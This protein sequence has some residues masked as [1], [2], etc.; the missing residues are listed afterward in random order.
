MRLRSRHAWS[1]VLVALFAL[2]VLRPEGFPGLE[3]SL[4]GWLNWTS[5]LGFG[6]PHAW[7]VAPVG[8]AGT[9]R[10]K[11]LEVIA[12]EQR[13]SYYR[14][15]DELVQRQSL[16][17]TLA[18]VGRLPVALEARILRAKDA[19]SK[20]RSI[21]I[22]RGTADGVVEG[23]AV[24]QGSRLVGLVQRVDE[25]AARVQLVTDPAFRLE[26]CVRSQEGQRAGAYLRGGD[27]DA[28]ALR[29]VRVLPGFTVRRDDPVLTSNGSEKVPDGLVVGRV[30]EADDLELETLRDVR[31][32]PLFDL[33]AS[34]TVLVLLPAR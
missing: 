13:E 32:R 5:R 21:L 33:E 18:G 20:R 1:A 19:S 28:L 26:V 11:D 7:R 9:Q 16:R 24:V 27:D 12:L 31:M 30:I 34:T 6:N 14:L 15:L 3:G 8:G 2:P 25:H 4:D 29:N 10:E 22:D 17:D 23:L